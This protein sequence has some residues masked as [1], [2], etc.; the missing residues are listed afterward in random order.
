MTGR[1]GV[2]PLLGTVKALQDHYYPCN[3]NADF[4]FPGHGFI[5]E[6]ACYSIPMEAQDVGKIEREN[7]DSLLLAWL[8]TYKDSSHGCSMQQHIHVI[9]SIAFLARCSSCQHII[10][11]T[12][13]RTSSR[14]EMTKPC[15]PSRQLLKAST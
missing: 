1:G 4:T 5:L 6:C 9:A 8:S 15:S 10:K 13:S 11:P 2:W 3:T 14:P 7:C 12:H